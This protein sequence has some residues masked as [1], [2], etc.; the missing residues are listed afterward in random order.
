MFN[1]P[2]IETVLPVAILGPMSLDLVNDDDEA[3]APVA[4]KSRCEES[5]APYPSEG[6]DEVDD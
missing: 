1:D 2:Y 6:S 5:R 4:F 3:L